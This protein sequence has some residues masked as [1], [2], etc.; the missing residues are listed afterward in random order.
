MG[1]ALMQGGGTNVALAIFITY[2]V[3]QFIQTY[4]LEP[5]VVGREVNINPLF[6]IG[7]LVAGEL[8]WGIGGMV[9]AIP[10]MGILK[11]IFDH[12]EPLKPYGELMGEDKKEAKGLKKKIKELAASIKDRVSSR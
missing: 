12:I 8:V 2:V 5:L 10:I 4:L 11:I 1:V 7:G 3:V 6:T 9:L